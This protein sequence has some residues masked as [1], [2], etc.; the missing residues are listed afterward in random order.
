MK[1]NLFFTV[2]VSLFIAT[3]ITSC[4]D[5]NI[6]GNN[7]GLGIYTPP[8]DMTV[9]DFTRLL[10]E[11]KEAVFKESFTAKGI[12]TT[13]SALT[14]GDGEPVKMNNKTRSTTEMN[15]NTK[16]YLTTEYAMAGSENYLP[17]QLLALVYIDGYTLY[18]MQ[19]SYSAS[20]MESRKATD[21]NVDW[22]LEFI[23]NEGNS[24]GE[25]NYYDCKINGD[26]ITVKANLSP[27]SF[28]KTNLTLKIV[29]T[30]DKR[31]RYI[32]T[33]ISQNSAIFNSFTTSEATYA[34]GIT[35]PVLPGNF[36]T[37]D[38]TPIPQYS[39]QVEWG[40]GKSNTFYTNKVEDG[41]GTIETAYI[42][43]F[44]PSVAEKQ[45]YLYNSN[46]EKESGIIEINADNQQF[47]VQWE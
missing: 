35:N 1:K 45:P 44:A 2:L 7:D 18:N 42:L 3:A 22:S 10:E 12:A 30:K 29:L 23:L 26:T 17:N 13:S 6:G 27:E 41:I 21:A 33:E 20:V 31:Y 37:S 24:E 34:Y 4:G 32:K 36:K 28:I 11:V 14:L 40:N 16:K 8:A 46:G 9:D 39:L 19:Y 43:N 15:R 38:F 25:I 5:D 47:H